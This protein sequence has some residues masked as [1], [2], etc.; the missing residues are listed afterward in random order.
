[1]KNWSILAAVML[2]VALCPYSAQGIDR[3]KKEVQPKTTKVVLGKYD[4]LF[5]NKAHVVAKGGFMTLHKVDGKLFFEMPLKY[6]GRE[7]LLASTVT[8]ATDNS[9]CVVGYKPRTPRHIKF[10]LLDSMVCLRNVNSKMTYD[11][12]QAGLEEAMEKNFGAYQQKQLF[13]IQ[14]FLNGQE[15]LLRI[16][17]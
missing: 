2:V 13:S 9:I 12:G 1:M 3:K 14:C 8:S 17:G 5:K 15:C 4:E 6:M 7:F 16:T 10:T 11:K